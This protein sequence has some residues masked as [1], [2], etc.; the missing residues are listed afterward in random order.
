M[1]NDRGGL[2]LMAASLGGRI[3]KRVAA[4]RSI[5]LPSRKPHDGGR[6]GFLGG[7]F[8]EADQDVVGMTV[9]VA[10]GPV[11]PRRHPGVA[12]LRGDSPALSIDCSRRHPDTRS[13]IL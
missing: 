4:R 7:S 8:N 5:C 2:V 13:A 6:G 3:T 12:V 1:T 10:A 11:I 9:E